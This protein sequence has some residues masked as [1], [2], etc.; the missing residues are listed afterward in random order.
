MFRTH[1]W[2][3]S[4]ARQWIQFAGQER[5]QH[6][7]R[8]SQQRSRSAIPATMIASATPPCAAANRPSLPHAEQHGR[9]E[10]TT[11]SPSGGAWHSFPARRRVSGARRR[12]HCPSPVGANCHH[13]THCPSSTWRVAVPSLRA[14]SSG[15]MARLMAEASLHEKSFR[16]LPLFVD[17]FCQPK[18]RSADRNRKLG[19]QLSKRLKHMIVPA[20]GVPRSPQAVRAGF[21]VGAV[22]VGGRD[23]DKM[24][25]IS[26]TAVWQRRPPLLLR[27]QLSGCS[28][29]IAEP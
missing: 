1:A 9:A 17:V 20:I 14:F 10:H 8:R 29:D 12:R 19:H 24:V 22:F 11:K 7:G 21:V 26:K 2:M 28:G 16:H 4:L 13:A 5:H 15:S 18:I 6:Q 25:G 3:H 27:D 23:V